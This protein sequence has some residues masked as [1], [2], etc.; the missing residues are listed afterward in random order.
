MYRQW[1][2]H[3]A[4]KFNPFFFFKDFL[5]TSLTGKADDLLFFFSLRCA[6]YV[7]VKVARRLG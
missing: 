5:S 7:P 4:S 2:G 3:R 1:E 6:N